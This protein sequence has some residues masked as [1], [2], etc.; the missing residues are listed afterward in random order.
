[1]NRHARRVFPWLLALI[2]CLPL[3]SCIEYVKGDL[4][5]PEIAPAPPEFKKLSAT[6]ELSLDLIPIPEQGDP[7]EF[8]QLE[9]GEFPPFQPGCDATR[10]WIA[11]ICRRELR[12][13]LMSSGYFAAVDESVERG[14]VHFKVTTARHGSSFLSMNPGEWT[15][16]S[17]VLPAWAAD[18]RIYHVEVLQNEREA[19][20]YDVK[21]TVMTIGW[22]P[23]MIAAP[24][25]EHADSRN[26]RIFHAVFRDVVSRMRVDGAFGA[27]P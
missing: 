15:T 16:F 10:P 4:P 12:D 5:S 23:L 25:N 7:E 2:A 20:S 22:T 6:F 13:V 27:S 11:D 24:F 17:I 18:D 19:K 9:R 3:A 14:D 21:A 8:R 1:M 26:A